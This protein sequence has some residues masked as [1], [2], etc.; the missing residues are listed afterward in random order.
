[1]LVEEVMTTDLVTC[2]ADAA[3]RDATERMLRNR[4]GS[5]VV[6]DDGTPAGILTESDVLR[7]GY[8]TDDPLSAI[9]V[10]KAASA[11]LVT[12]RPSATLR[13]ATKRMRSEGVKKLVVVDGTTPVGIVTTQ[14]IVDNYAGIRKEVH[15]LA[16]DATGWSERSDRLDE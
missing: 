2:G 16:T 10:R 6:T 8:A 3:V 9:P 12:V 4:V 1:M 7:A 14:D 5:V 11:P 13:T 15:D